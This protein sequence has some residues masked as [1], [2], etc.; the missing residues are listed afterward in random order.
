[1]KRSLKRFG[2]WIARFALQVHLGPR[3]GSLGARVIGADP[4]EEWEQRRV[5]AEELDRKP[6]LE[7]D[8]DS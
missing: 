6:A 8:P 7:H 4:I 3:F 5:E 2:Q 1:M